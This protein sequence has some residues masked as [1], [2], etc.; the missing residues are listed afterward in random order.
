MV[1]FRDVCISNWRA[2]KKSEE[3]NNITNDLSLWT[4]SVRRLHEHEPYS[5]ESVVPEVVEE[6]KKNIVVYRIIY[7]HTAYRRL[8]KWK[9][10]FRY[11]VVGRSA[12]MKY[13]RETWT[14]SGLLAYKLKYKWYSKIIYGYAYDALNFIIFHSFIWYKFKWSWKKGFFSCS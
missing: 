14:I 10:W 4:W 6:V 11:G 5:R 9:Q 2:C 7:T 3:K 8:N 12:R 1:S 13:V